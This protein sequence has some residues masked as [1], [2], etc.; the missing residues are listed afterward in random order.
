MGLNIGDPASPDGQADKG[1]VL[2]VAILRVCKLRPSP[3]PPPPQLSGP[4]QTTQAN[5]YLFIRHAISHQRTEA[6]HPIP[7]WS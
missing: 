2:S 7:T 6:A 3:S 1:L 4:G 5:M